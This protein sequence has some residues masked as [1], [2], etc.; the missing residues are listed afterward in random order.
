MPTAAAAPVRAGLSRPQ[1]VLFDWDNTLA[2]NWASIHAALAAAFT[3]MG[4]EPW[5]LAE[6]RQR[7]RQSLRDSFPALFGP[8][9]PQAREIFY[10]HFEARHLEHLQPLPG[11]EKLLRALS[12]AG[13]YLALVSNKTGPYLRKE[14]EA[15]GWSGFFGAL[16]GATDAPADKPDPA[17][18]H[19]ALAPA[20]LA[21]SASVWFVG[22]TDI[23]LQCAHASGCL[24]VLVGPDN[25]F[26]H[27]F[28]APALHVR[29]CL[30]L[31]DL[32]R[33]L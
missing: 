17:P 18:V 28:F 23:D 30:S 5:T 9:W 13:I 16:V 31:C 24:P 33:A 22:D 12:E 25:P 20:G 3:A 10:A 32:V 29:D 7:V 27:E 14:A 21:P 2:D 6:T 19:Q 26:A 11:A 15:L 8:R 4:Q 1:A